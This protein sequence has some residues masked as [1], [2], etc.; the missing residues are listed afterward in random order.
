MHSKVI[1]ATLLGLE[2][3]KVEV[4]VDYR[5][6]LSFFSIVGLGDKS[7]QESKE[8]VISAISNSD[9]KLLP[10]KITVNLAP[11]DMPKHGP[12]FDLAIA[13]GL[14][15]STRQ[16]PT[17]SPEVALLGELALGGQLRPVK[18]I[19]SLVDGLKTEGIKTVIIPVANFQQARLVKDLKFVPLASLA[20]VISYLKGYLEVESPSVLERFTNDGLV[21]FA[22]PE[23]DF[24]QIYGQLHVK[25][26]LEI[27]AA[28]KHNVLMKG[29]PGAGKSLLA[30]ALPGILPELTFDEM[31][32]VTK[33]YS[34]SH[35]LENRNEVLYSTRPFRAPHH[36][37][38]SPAMLGGGNLPH[39]GEL[40]LAHHGVLF[41]D[42]LPQYSPTL[43]D[44]LR[45]PMQ[46]KKI[47]VVRSRYSIDFPADFILVAAMNP[48]RCGYF[49]S[50]QRKCI[51]TNYQVRSYQQRVSGPLLDR[52]DLTVSIDRID[53]VSLFQKQ[54]SE[55]SEQ[56]KLRV[57]AATEH[58]SRAFSEKS[59]V[60][61]EAEHALRLAT[62]NLS[63][64]ARS[65]YSTLS[66]ARTIAAL[67]GRAHVIKEDVVES[68]GYRT[69]G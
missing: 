62:V 43:L 31:L 65:Y 26:V 59:L 61:E 53:Y 45:Q 38:S 69:G 46:D 25:R 16:L 42:E 49:G 11:A 7:V 6:G 3:R 60:D 64:S 2:C 44:S 10:Q 20:Q 52:F 54:K 51:C 22:K 33:I 21:G 17:L 24:D 14:L 30:Q 15:I 48:C 18:G 1:S 39:P 29:V 12:N 47:K 55:S 8:R 40:T 50:S 36:T 5:S 32:E 56:V 35:K 4:E 41:L 28:G 13:I 68:L 37:I 66:V 57:T 63:L 67:D 19:I 23:V 58:L 9:V 27:A 34:I